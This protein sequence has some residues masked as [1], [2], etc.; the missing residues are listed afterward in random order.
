MS[1]SRV[2]K[3]NRAYIDRDM[4]WVSFVRMVFIAWGR[5]EKVVQAAAS[6]PTRVI[7]FTGKIY[8]KIRFFHRVREIE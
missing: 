4:L 3:V 1:Q 6:R 8:G 7:R 2:P 5:K